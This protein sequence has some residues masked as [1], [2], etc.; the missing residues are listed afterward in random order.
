MWRFSARLLFTPLL[1]SID[2]INEL[3]DR[4]KAL[5]VY[6]L[7]TWFHLNECSFKYKSNSDNATDMRLY[8]GRYRRWLCRRRTHSARAGPADTRSTAW[9]CTGP[10]IEPC[11]GI[12]CR[13]CSPAPCV[14]NNQQVSRVA[15]EQSCCRL[16]YCDPFFDN[17]VHNTKLWPLSF[18]M[19][20]ITLSCNLFLFM[21]SFTSTTGHSHYM[22][23]TGTEQLC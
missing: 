3:N 8:L 9:V 1:F 5:R 23:K 4:L 6:K 13:R 15:N 10:R 7:L 11:P 21:I 18:T 19:S 12:C 22:S 17:V 14:T 16:Q 2:I 20:F